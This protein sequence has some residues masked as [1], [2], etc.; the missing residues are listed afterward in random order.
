MKNRIYIFNSG[1]LKRS[2]NTLIFTNEKTGKKKVLPVEAI[3]EIIVFGELDINK[4]L[5]DF[6]N[7]KRIV[8][9]FFNYYGYYIGTYY[10]REYLNSGLI[11]LKQVE[12]YICDE[13]RLELA[14]KFVKG[15]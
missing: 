3:D 10:P 14:K 13:K 7:T 8:I 15:S 5:L 1:V 2:E 11:I 4:R 6:L 12:H 9:H